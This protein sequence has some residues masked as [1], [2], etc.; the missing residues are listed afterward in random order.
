[1]TAI[2]DIMTIRRTALGELTHARPPRRAPF[3][4]LRLDLDRFAPGSPDPAD[5]P[6]S[7]AAAVRTLLARGGENA[8]PGAVV[9]SGL[10]RHFSGPAARVFHEALFR[11]VWDGFRRDLD[12]DGTA[13]FRMKTG[14]IADGEIPVQL[15]G[16]SWSF[17]RLHIDREALLFSHLYGP[18]Q[19]FTGGRVLLV[20]IHH[21]MSRRSLGFADVFEWSD[22]PTE[23]SKP[24]LREEHATAA[25]A[26]CGVDIGPIGPD[27]VLFVNNTPGAGI[28]HGVTPVSVTDPASY[29]RE[30]HRCSV[31]ELPQ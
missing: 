13:R 20:D 3:A 25:L 12:P 14:T 16:S 1:M 4:G 9:V 7:L 21:Y 10:A 11:A 18:V 17:K 15:Y 5:P 2:T 30:Y 27:A 22:E 8:G 19:G 6:A 31:K 24:V 29:R 23:G 28:L 26:E